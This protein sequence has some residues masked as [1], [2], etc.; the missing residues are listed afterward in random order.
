M[1]CGGDHTLALSAPGTAYAWG[2]G[3]WGQLGMGSEDNTCRPA[4]VKGSLEGV[5]VLQVAAGSRHS[6][7]LTSNNVLF[8]WGCG[9]QGQL[10]CGSAV[11]KQLTPRPVTG[12]PPSAAVLFIAAGGEHALAVVKGVTGT[13]QFVVG[14]LP[15]GLAPPGV[16]PHGFGCVALG[17]PP[18]IELAEA[19]AVTGSQGATGSERTTGARPSAPAAGVASGGG[20]GAG[21]AGSGGSSTASSSALHA[22][23][24]AVEDVWSSPGYLAAGF[25]RPRA[26]DSAPGDAVHCFAHVLQPDQG[27]LEQQHCCMLDAGEALAPAHISHAC[28]ACPL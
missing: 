18:L 14:P 22:L 13:E 25:A 4:A 11:A 3:A 1:S 28:C 8:A 26:D 2:R 15:P 20:G 19:A 6:L 16:V 21:G 9:E 12:M 23:C 7:A 24:L 10:G 17:L 5:R 27:Y